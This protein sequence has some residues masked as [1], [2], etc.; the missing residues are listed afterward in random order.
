MVTTLRVDVE[1]WKDGM[2]VGWQSTAHVLHWIWMSCFAELVRFHGRSI[3][4]QDRDFLHITP[5]LVYLYYQFLYIGRMPSI[6]YLYTCFGWYSN[7]HRHCK[8]SYP[9]LHLQECGCEV[10][11]LPRTQKF[12][13]KVFTPLIH[14]SV[15]YGTVSPMSSLNKHKGHYQQEYLTVIYMRHMHSTNEYGPS[16]LLVAP[17]HISII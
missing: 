12:I 15:D 10:L 11:I 1:I 4:P 5:V 14:F 8:F 6:L 17:S 16:Y 7:V 9:S 3:F 13:S 2:S